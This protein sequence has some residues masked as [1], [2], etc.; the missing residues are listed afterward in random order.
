MRL[1]VS[2]GNSAMAMRT[3]EPDIASVT[4]DHRPYR[5]GQAVLAVT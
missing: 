4:L 5:P 2:C 3:A 1:A